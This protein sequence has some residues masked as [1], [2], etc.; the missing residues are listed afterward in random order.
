MNGRGGPS[1]KPVTGANARPAG[2]EQGAH[3]GPPPDS[4]GTKRQVAI[5][6]LRSRLWFRLRRRALWRA[7]GRVRGGLAQL[8]TAT[9]GA[10]PKDAAT[11]RLLRRQIFRIVLFFEPPPWRGALW[12]LFMLVPLVFALPVGVGLLLGRPI[13]RVVTVPGAAVWTPS[14]VLAGALVVFLVVGGQW[15]LGS[16]WNRATSR[17]RSSHG[18]IDARLAEF[19]ALAILSLLLMVAGAHAA[20]TNLPGPVRFIVAPAC[21][22]LSLCALAWAL[23]AILWTVPE[24]IQFYVLARVCFQE[25]IVYELAFLL[26]YLDYYACRLQTSES[27]A[28]IA[29]RLEKVAGLFDTRFQSLL[30]LADATTVEF[31]ETTGH[32]IA[33]AFRKMVTTYCILGTTTVDELRGFLVQALVGSVKGEWAKLEAAPIREGSWFR[34]RRYRLVRGLSAVVVALIPGAVLLAV[35]ASPIAL[36]S[37][38]LGYARGIVVGWFAVVL[39]YNLVPR[40]GAGSERI[41]GILDVV[42]SLRGKD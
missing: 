33:G 20:L 16:H 21:V 5:S 39:L 37:P 29:R 32:G 1:V 40:G 14:L 36:E 23:M 11:T 2:A 4:T 35:Q 13:L 28:W 22:L 3:R 12:D 7:R 6:A 38:V 10:L 18:V 31:L 26:V 19:G 27:R 42:R 9:R 30:P 34:L 24:A 17:P 25:T 8:G 41:K 15:A